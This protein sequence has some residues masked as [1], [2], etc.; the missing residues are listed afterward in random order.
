MEKI[1]SLLLVIL[2]FSLNS[3]AQV[4][5]AGRDRSREDIVIAEPANTKKSIGT[6]G[7]NGKYGFVSIDG[8][9]LEA[10]YDHI[11]WNYDGFVLK[12]DGL[13]GI[14]DKTGKLIGKLDY[15]SIA[16]PTFLFGDTYLIKKAG[17]YGTLSKMGMKILS[18]RYDKIL[19]SD[20][21]NGVSFIVNKDKSIQVISNVNEQVNSFQIDYAQ[22]YR[23]LIILKSKGKFGVLKKDVLIVPFDYDSI[24]YSTPAK[25][26]YKPDN[27]L[28]KNQDNF[29]AQN[30]DRNADNLI[31]KKGE[32][33]GI[34]DSLGQVVYPPELDEISF[35]GG[36]AFS[37]NYYTLKKDRL[38]GAYFPRSKK[39]INTEYHRIYPDGMDWVFLQKGLLKGAV[40]SQGNLI[41]P[42]EYDALMW[43]SRGF[44]AGKN[45][46]KGLID[47]K[48]NVLVP[49]I[50][51]DLSSFYEDDFR[52]FLKVTSNG[53]TGVVG[54]NNKVV[55]PAEFDGIGTIRGLFLA[56]TD[57]P[58]R[59]LGL[60]D[61][62]GKVLLPAKFQNIQK[63]INE[64]SKL[65]LLNRAD[66]AYN[67]L[68]AAS[69]LIFPEDV[70]SYGYVPDADKLL[71]A[72]SRNKQHF[73]CV[74]SK[75]GKYGLLNELTGK[76]D[77]PML[78]DEIVQ[79]FESRKHTYFTVSK[80][81]KYGLINELG[82]TVIPF[83][84]DALSIDMLPVDYDDVTD[85]TYL[86][87]AAK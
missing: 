54:L 57:E 41:I 21:K 7:Q 24:F 46:K 80:N 50:Y 44:E 65:I 53:K 60:Y 48:G 69:Q 33:F 1:R 22:P 42:V 67:F 84:Y 63:S 43:S 11:E 34:I 73:I 4:P 39:K 6:Y 71:N 66:H 37:R 17:K 52:D 58:D 56:V 20:T 16:S 64:D 3:Y 27:R 45:K 28:K 25:T 13:Y 75:A 81:K 9:R 79:R 5:P 40:N 55:V 82:Q 49:I 83:I 74:R 26:L 15:D 62:S 10:I 87:V 70:S 86:V 2:C 32:K 30:S 51:D 76:P 29:N 23:N 18:A 38:F 61:R 12:K 36:T 19:F 77:V 59:K 31:V 47:H 72:E 35:D 8:Q 68:N 85:G 14:A 78:Y